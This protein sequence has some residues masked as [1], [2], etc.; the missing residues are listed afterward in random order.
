MHTTTL[1]VRFG[2][3]DLAGHVNN[4]VY[5]SYLEEARL[6]FLREVLKLDDVPFILASAKLDFLGQMRYPDSMVITCG[7][8]RI[9]RSSFDMVHQLFR[10][11]DHALALTA[12]VTLVAFD[13]QLQRPTPIPQ[14]WR[15]LL[16][17]HGVAEPP[18][19]T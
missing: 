9:G 17:P 1:T 11:P 14:N 19:R 2:E 7:V 10:L 16:E 12:I 3:T 18:P 15:Q 4:A 13:Y 8:S 6:T 5:L